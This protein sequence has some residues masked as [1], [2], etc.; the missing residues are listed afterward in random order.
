MRTRTAAAVERFFETALLGL[1]ASGYGALL[2]TG[3]LPLDLAA[4]AGL[5]ILLR[6]AIVTGWLRLPT[7]KWAYLVPGLI[8]LGWPV[9]AI[10]LDPRRMDYALS[11][12][13]YLFC[14]VSIVFASSRSECVFLALIAL[15]E[16]AAAAVLSSS[17]LFFVFLALFAGFSLA[18]L[19]AAES[20]AGPKG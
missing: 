11:M 20:A 18:A 14:A 16:L 2:A 7:G 5:A 10:M 6:C 12:S 13:F 3:R 1:L 8:C 17:P 19:M 9:L 4:P 15:L